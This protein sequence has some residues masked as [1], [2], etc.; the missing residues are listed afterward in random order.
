MDDQSN[1]RHTEKRV[2]PHKTQ[3][4]AVAQNP[5]ALLTITTSAALIARGVSTLYALAAKD[6]TFPKLI[7]RGKRCTRIR[8]GDLTAWLK[9][10]AQS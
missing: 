3:P 7:K 10:Q 5:D 8:A 2:Q 9:A 1:V 6:P 4:L